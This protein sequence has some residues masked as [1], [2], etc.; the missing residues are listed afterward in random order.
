MADAGRWSVIFYQHDHEKNG[1]IILTF[2]DITYVN[3]YFFLCNSKF[4][5]LMLNFFNL[6]YLINIK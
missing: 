4:F 2:N 1:K 5:I 6:I 3:I